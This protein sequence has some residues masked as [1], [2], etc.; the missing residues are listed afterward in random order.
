MPDLQ[1]LKDIVTDEISL[2]GTP[3]V[4]DAEFVVLYKGEDEDEYMPVEKEEDGHKPNEAMMTAAKRGLEWRDEFNRGGTEIGVARARDISNGKSLSMDT[5]KRMVSYFARHEVDSNAEGFNS[6]EEGFPSAG[7]IAW[8]LW[9][10]DAGKTWAN[11][12]AS[13]DDVKKDCFNKTEPVEKREFT[14]EERDEAAEE[15]NAMPDGSYPILNRSDLE[16]AIQ[17][18][19]RASDP[20]GVKAHIKRRAKELGLEELI[21]ET[22][23]EKGCDEYSDEE[24]E[25]ACSYM[26]RHKGSMSSAMK[27][28]VV[29]LALGMAEDMEDEDENEIEIHVGKSLESIIEQKVE[30]ILKSKETPVVEESTEVEKAAP[31]PVETE[32]VIAKAARLLAE[33]NES[34]RLAKEAAARAS[35]NEALFGLLNEVKSLRE[36]HEDLRSK[37]DREMGRG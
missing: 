28:R 8:E 10:G 33:R 11:E 31:E 17:A 35:L 18:Y 13:R 6:G 4:P 16:N 29:D 19:G 15:G 9:G 34:A 3:A 5:V 32:D 37:L 14:E 27:K 22:W 36:G 23:L 30:A 20:E 7:R 24:M 25:K 12:I 21:P 1:E 26:D 2:V